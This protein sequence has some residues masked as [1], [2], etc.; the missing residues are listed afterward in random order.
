MPSGPKLGTLRAM[1]RRLV[2]V[3]GLALAWGCAKPPPPPSVNPATTQ[4]VED[5]G[6]TF[7]MQ[8][9]WQS[10]GA[11]EVKIV[12]EM[13]AKSIEQTDNLVVDVSTNGFVISSGTP[14]WVGFIQPRQR[15]EHEVTY[16]LLDGEE[17]G[18][19]TVTL[20][21]SMDGTLIWDTELLFVAEGGKVVLAQ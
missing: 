21:R 15:Y 5:Q 16:K 7:D 3:L 1:L 2:P 6:A 17:S 10:V 9:G 11:D 20:R 12:I 18:R 19:A 8:I 4:T 14:Q 13:V